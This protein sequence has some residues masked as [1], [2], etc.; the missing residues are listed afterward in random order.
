MR[1]YVALQ[2]IQN[3]DRYQA[4]GLTPYH[5]HG[6]PPGVEFACFV[7]AE[8]G[9]EDERI[10]VWREEEQAEYLKEHPL[11]VAA[12]DLGDDAPDAPDIED[13]DAKKAA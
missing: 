4:I 9:V 6:A 11:P 13:G 3:K 12:A 5:A 7:L 1:R 8:M 2:N 10:Q